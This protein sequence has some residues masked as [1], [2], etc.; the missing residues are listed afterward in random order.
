MSD[1]KRAFYRVMVGNIDPDASQEDY[2]VQ[3]LYTSQEWHYVMAPEPR[4]AVA[5]AMG[6]EL[7]AYTW[8]GLYGHSKVAQVRDRIFVAKVRRTVDGVTGTPKIPLA[9]VTPE[10]EVLASPL[11]PTRY[12]GDPPLRPLNV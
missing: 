1:V 6:A 9:D 12:V 8:E 11:P 4:P 5:E 2:D 3:V 7:L 10:D